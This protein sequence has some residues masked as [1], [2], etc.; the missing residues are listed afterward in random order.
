MHFAAQ[1]SS[2]KIKYITALPNPQYIVW[3]RKFQLTTNAE[4]YAIGKGRNS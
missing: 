2:V 1:T 3:Q 4:T